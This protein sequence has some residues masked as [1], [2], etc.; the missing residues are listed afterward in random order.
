MSM[1]EY[2]EQAQKQKGSRNILDADPRFVTIDERTGEQVNSLGE[3]MK[4]GQFDFEYAKKELERINQEIATDNAK[5]LEVYRKNMASQPASMKDQMIQS[6]LTALVG[7]GSFNPP[8]PGG[9][10]GGLND[11][12]KNLLDQINN[13]VVPPP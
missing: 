6:L 3:A 11:K 10:G 5:V 2:Y 4:D 12:S 9:G 1:K 13:P 8:N 7:G